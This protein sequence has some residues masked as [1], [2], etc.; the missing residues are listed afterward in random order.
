M[1]VFTVLFSIILYLILPKSVSTA[2]INRA[3]RTKRVMTNVPHL[4]IFWKIVFLPLTLLFSLL[5]AVIKT[6]FIWVLSCKTYYDIQYTL[7]LFYDDITSSHIKRSFREAIKRTVLLWELIIKGKEKKASFG[8][9]NPHKTFYIIRPYYFMDYNELMPYLLNLLAHYNYT[10]QHIAYAV[11]KD[12]VPV[13]DW[14]NYG[15]FL[16][17]EGYPINDTKSC[18]EY[19]WNQPSKYTLGE[20]Y[21]S[22]NVV[23]S[24]RNWRNGDNYIPTAVP[25]SPLQEYAMQHAQKCPKYDRLITFN[26]PTAKYIQE[27]QNMLFPKDANILGVSVR[28]TSY[29]E[30]GISNHPIQ[31]RMTDLIRLVRKTVRDWKANYIFFACESEYAVNELHEAFGKQ[32]LVLPRM[33]HKESPTVEKN[34]LYEPGLRYQTNLD[35]ITEMVLL[36]RCNSL[37]ASMSSGTKAAIIWNANRYE[38]MKIIDLGVWQ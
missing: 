32:M 22:K 11:E 13:V 7:V 23:L 30:N 4:R 38:H 15:P 14:E 17:G 16:H 12:W 9:K 29:G 3:V 8:E 2:I 6:I 19:F 10:L 27:K 28:A 18:W 36:S 26:E 5:E 21:Q 25:W 37:L 34:P 20:V 31:P 35:Y 33:R 24:E 1:R